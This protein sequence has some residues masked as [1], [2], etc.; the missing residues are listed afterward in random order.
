MGGGGE[1]RGGGSR[2]RQNW[3]GMCVCECVYVC[4]C[5]CGG[6]GGGG[7]GDSLSAMY[8]RMAYSPPAVIFLAGTKF[9]TIKKPKK[10][11]ALL[12]VN[13]PLCIMVWGQSKGGVMKEGGRISVVGQLVC[14]CCIIT[15][16]GELG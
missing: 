6:G 10:E 15:K 13:V 16:R 1:W 5:V 9:Y 12:Y 2:S 8:K 7:G 11:A 3:M 14:Q 4:V